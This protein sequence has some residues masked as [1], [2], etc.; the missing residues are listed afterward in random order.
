MND[1]IIQQLKDEGVIKIPNFFNS[2]ELDLRRKIINKY[3]APKGDA[4]VFDEG[5]V[6]KGSKSLI[7]DRMVLRYLYSIKK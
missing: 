1:N 5:G 3:K 7:N 6:H 4:I 2:E